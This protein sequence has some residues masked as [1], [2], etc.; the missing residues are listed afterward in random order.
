MVSLA[1]MFILQQVQEERVM[2]SFAGM[3]ILQQVQDERIL[4]LRPR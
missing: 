3:F 1:G 4:R 2:L